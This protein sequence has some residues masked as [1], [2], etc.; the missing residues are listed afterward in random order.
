MKKELE[1]LY[2]IANL[3]GE[4]SQKQKQQMLIDNDSET[5]REL[6]NIALNPFIITRINKFEVTDNVLISID[7]DP[8]DF[9]TL[10]DKL[11]TMKS[12][13]N[14]WRR[15]ADNVVNSID[16]PKEHR[17]I[18]AK[19]LTKNFNI[20]LGTRNVN[21]AFGADFI[22]DPSL[23]LAEDD[24]EQ[25]LKFKS[26]SVEHKYDGVRVIAVIE[27][28]DKVVFYTRNFNEL[29]ADSMPNLRDNILEMVK[30]GLIGVGEF[31]DGELTDFDRKSVSG[32]VNRILKS[33]NDL[34]GIDND[35]LFN[36]FDIEHKD[37]LT[38]GK[39]YNDYGV[40]R[41]ALEAIKRNMGTKK[42]ISIVESFA[43]D[44]LDDVMSIYNKIIKDGGEGVIVK[45]ADHVYECRRSRQWIKFK[46]VQDC[47]LKIVGTVPGKGKRAEM[48]GG[49]MCES[50]CGKLKVN[51]GSGFTDMELKEYADN[52]QNYVG[53][54]AAVQYNVRI[55]NKQG[56]H[57]LF[58]PVFIEVRSDKTIANTLEEI[59]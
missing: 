1:V 31:F 55:T 25:L 9:F 40:R 8:I 5:L 15:I 4:G 12:I 37:T 48:I 3:T 38:S 11:K 21:K 23:M 32:K 54:I 16:A 27:S 29:K 28:K 49:F 30:D 51:V 33:P 10:V 57:S 19:I 41:Q 18:L 17:E 46:E 58:L 50:E 6:L 52:F 26:Y 34:T 42:H 20:G 53:K 13:N 56:Q 44:S 45:N 36:V 7:E 59:K 14:E 39:G 47:D 43:A 2:N 35:F 24:Q 22:P